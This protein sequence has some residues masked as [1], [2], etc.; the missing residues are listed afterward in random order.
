MCLF[1][2]ASD[3]IE[4]LCISFVLPSAECDL[5]LSTTDKGYLSSV[6]FAGMMIGGYVWG[7]LAD[8]SGS[9]IFSSPKSKIKLGSVCFIFIVNVKRSAIDIDSSAF[10]QRCV[11]HAIRSESVVSTTFIF[12]IFEWN[13][14]II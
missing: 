8:I 4:I 7:T 9:F 3:A 11:C 12:Q 2:N 5:D 1:A 13:R 10:I 6:T 14:V